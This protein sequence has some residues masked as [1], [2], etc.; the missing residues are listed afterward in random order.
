MTNGEI[1]LGKNILSNCTHQVT[2]E[3][4]IPNSNKILSKE[5]SHKIKSIEYNGAATKINM[6][7]KGLPKFKCLKNS[8]LS[9]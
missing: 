4:L 6:A 8:N 9:L 5:L 7:I 3:K 2:F 1:I